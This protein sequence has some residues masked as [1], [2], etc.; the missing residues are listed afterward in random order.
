V[1]PPHAG[2][3][4]ALSLLALAAAGAL[5]GCSGGRGEP[6]RRLP[7]DA[8][9]PLLYVALGDGGSDRGKVVG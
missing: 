2:R 7:R 8:T 1:V 6:A 4:R 9:T 3:R 5:V